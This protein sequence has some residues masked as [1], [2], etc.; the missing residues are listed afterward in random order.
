MQA[1]TGDHAWVHRRPGQSIGDVRV[2]GHILE[3]RNAHC[4]QGKVRRLGKPREMTMG[5]AIYRGP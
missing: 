2:Q 3:T 4:R 1:S 5:L